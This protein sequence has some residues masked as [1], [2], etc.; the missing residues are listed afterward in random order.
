M[1]KKTAKQVVLPI[2]L[3]IL[4]AL[5]TTIFVACPKQEDNYPVAGIWHARA[6]WHEDS[7]MN[8]G[9]YNYVLDIYFEFREDGTIRNK[10]NLKMN[11]FEVKDDFSD[12]VILNLTWTVSAN[13]I[14][15]SSG[16]TYVIV[17]DQFDDIYGSTQII[18]HYKK[19]S[20]SK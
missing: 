7:P 14:T 6:T 12:W 2:L 8:Y 18:L 11:D 19:E 13:T 17:D 3:I 20:A 16:K 10:R 1:Y 4:I 5:S 9:G 15:L